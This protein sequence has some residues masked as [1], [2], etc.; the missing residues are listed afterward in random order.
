M[1]VAFKTEKVMSK[2]V[3]GSSDVSRIKESDTAA[4]GSRASP[5]RVAV[6]AG[7]REVQMAETMRLNQ[8]TMADGG[9][10]WRTIVAWLGSGG[11]PV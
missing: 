10:I 1:Q 9:R 5:L 8:L 2:E 6:G 11:C 3:R 7:Q 4:A